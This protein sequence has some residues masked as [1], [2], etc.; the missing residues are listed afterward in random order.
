MLGWKD[1]N[2]KAIHNL[3]EQG[4]GNRKKKAKGKSF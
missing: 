1:S 4:T 2:K 3:R